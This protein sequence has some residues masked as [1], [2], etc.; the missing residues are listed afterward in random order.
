MVVAVHGCHEHAIH[1]HVY[2]VSLHR[3]GEVVPPP[4][5]P[6]T[7]IQAHTRQPVEPPLCVG[8]AAAAELDAHNVVHELRA[9]RMVHELQR[10]AVLLLV[11]PNTGRGAAGRDACLTE[12]RQRRHVG[13]RH[14]AVTQVCCRLV[15][16]DWLDPCSQRQASPA[17][18][19]QR[20][21]SRR[22]DL[23]VAAQ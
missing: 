6:A 18:A 5:G 11:A 19:E 2:G 8:S 7:L 22:R 13:P 1:E 12:Q 10:D 21:A 14:D 16:S 17:L 4:S 15:T 3:H 23:K 20:Q 9:A